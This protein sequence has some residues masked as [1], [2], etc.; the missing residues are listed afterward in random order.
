[1][2]RRRRNEGVALNFDGLTDAVTNLTGTLILLVVLIF[3]ITTE[4]RTPAPPPPPPPAPRTRQGKPI[5]P[6][7][8]KIEILKLQIEQTDKQIRTLKDDLP[9]LE[10]EAEQLQQE[11]DELW[12]RSGR[13]KPGLQAHRTRGDGNRSTWR[14]RA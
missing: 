6:L 12:N 2:A 9:R 14:R 1:M 3:G 8:Q 11:A 4:A 5:L 7:L 10:A 13:E